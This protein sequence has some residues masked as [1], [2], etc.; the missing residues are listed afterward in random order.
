MC[1][2]L[3]SVGRLTSFSTTGLYR[4]RSPQLPLD[5]FAPLIWNNFATPQA[6][7]FLWLVCRHRVP[8]YVLLFHRHITNFD[9]C[10][11]S[12]RPT[13]GSTTYFLLLSGSCSSLVSVVA[14]ALLFESSGGRSLG[15]SGVLKYHPGGPIYYYYIHSSDPPVRGVLCG[16]INDLSLAVSSYEHPLQS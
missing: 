4:A 8:T 7:Q 16:L 13:G 6:K 15:P 3:Q 11:S 9:S 2:A 14:A 1:Q 12:L 10:A 5:C